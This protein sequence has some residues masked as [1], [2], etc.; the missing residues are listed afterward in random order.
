M[1]LHTGEAIVPKSDLHRSLGLGT[2][3]CHHH[4]SSRHPHLSFLSSSI[5]T[6]T[7]GRRRTTNIIFIDQETA[8]SSPLCLCRFL[9]TREG[10]K[11]A[12]PDSDS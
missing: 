5:S 10:P 7:P 6:I 12:L 1:L 3:P 4:P 8:P 2:V 11:P 9:S